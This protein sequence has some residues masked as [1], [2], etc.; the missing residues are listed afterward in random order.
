[1]KI[2]FHVALFL[3]AGVQSFAQDVT[4]KTL[5]AESSKAIKKDVIAA[6]TSKK[7]WKK[8]GIYSI[9]IGQGSLSNWASGGDN[10]SFSVSSLLNIYAFYQ[11]G[12]HS[13]DNSLDFNIGYINTTSLGG[14]KNDD[15]IDVL[16]K[17]GYSVSQK[18][19]LSTLFNFRS[20][21]FRGYNYN[22]NIKT[23]TSDFLSPGYFLFSVGMDYKPNKNLSIFISPITS[24]L[25]LVINDTLSARGSYGVEP[26]KKSTGELGA[27]A[28]VNFLKA[29]SKTITYKARMDLF[30]NYK[31]NPQ[32]VDLFMTNI[33]SAKISKSLSVN[34][35]LDMIYDDDV[36]L[37]GA[38]KTSPALQV[39]SILAIG[40]VVKF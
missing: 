13:W 38:N 21:F 6:D 22:D 19:S 10:F 28:S 11:K 36:R 40:F 14:R 17:Y 27:F 24:R 34:Y 2:I 15:R 7:A 39:K 4:V 12:K 29:L 8:G 9:N 23:F 1:M 35:T 20:Q 25:I 3:L 33:I 18:W 16:S 5:Q 32:N 26:G 31:H 37:F 30:S